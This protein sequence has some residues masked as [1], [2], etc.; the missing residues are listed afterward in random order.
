[1]WLQQWIAPMRGVFHQPRERGHRTEQSCPVVPSIA[2]CFGLLISSAGE[3]SEENASFCDPD[4][5]RIQRQENRVAY[6]DRC[7]VRCPQRIR[8][9]LYCGELRRGRRTLQ[10]RSH[11]YQIW[12]AH[13]ASGERARNRVRSLDGSPPNSPG[14]ARRFECAG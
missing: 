3:T 1:M 2:A 14:K 13:V 7:R 6:P 8:S 4:K 9:V 11:Y 12:W 5:A 10:Q